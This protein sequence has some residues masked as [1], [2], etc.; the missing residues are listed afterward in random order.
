MS[1]FCPTN[2]YIASD[3]EALIAAGYL[4]NE[5]PPFCCSAA[6]FIMVQYSKVEGFGSGVGHWLF[7]N[8]LYMPAT[9]IK[10]CIIQMTI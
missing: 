4:T 10:F 3:D 1:F 2:S 5:I 7:K 9:S 6:F 8:T